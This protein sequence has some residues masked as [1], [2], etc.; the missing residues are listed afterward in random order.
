MVRIYQIPSQIKLEAQYAA[1]R[2]AQQSEVA[3]LRQQL[4]IKSNEVRSLNV[5]ID[6][7]KSLNE[8]LKVGFD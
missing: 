7:L 2:D 5:S 6:S 1:K 4:E 3:D 8:E